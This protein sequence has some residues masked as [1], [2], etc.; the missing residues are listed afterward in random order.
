MTDPIEQAARASWNATRA[1]LTAEWDELTGCRPGSLGQ[2][3]RTR[4]L[5]L[6][7][8]AIAAIREPTDAM[9]AAAQDW[10]RHKYGQPIGN[11]DATGCWQVM[12]DAILDQQ[13]DKAP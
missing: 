9:L 4:H 13:P 5:E 1:P 2:R 7:R 6:V 10:S 12:L 11:E 3:A 8:T